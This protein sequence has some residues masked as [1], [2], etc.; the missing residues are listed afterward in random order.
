MIILSAHDD[1]LN[2]G[3]TWPEHERVFLTKIGGHYGFANS[4]FYENFFDSGRALAK[5]LDHFF[6]LKFF[7][8]VFP[9]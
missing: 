7:S 6:R 5:N 4:Q 8:K 1:V 2:N 9:L 3:V